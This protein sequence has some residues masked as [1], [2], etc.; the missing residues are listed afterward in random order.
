MAAAGWW[1]PDGSAGGA[2]EGTAKRIPDP[3]NGREP[4]PWD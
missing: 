1:G 3:S 2:E 4:P